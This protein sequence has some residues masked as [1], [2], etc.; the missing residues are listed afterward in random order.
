MT[1][2]EIEIHRDLVA[3]AQYE[4][5]WNEHEPETLRWRRRVVDRDVTCVLWHECEGDLHAHHVVTQQHLRKRGLSRHAW[6]R[7][8]GLTVC[9]RG[10][11]R[12][13]SALERIP[14]DVLPAEVVGFVTD[15]GLGWYLERYYQ[16]SAS[17]EEPEPSPSPHVLGRASV[18]GSGHLRDRT[19]QKR[20]RYFA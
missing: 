19:F 17:A 3:G 13:H 2:D 16:A 15:L 20:K 8:I 9:E 10:H 1:F 12:H 14:V 6:D 7:R 11:R 18:G 4:D 5:Y